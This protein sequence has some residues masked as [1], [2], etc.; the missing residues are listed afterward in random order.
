[1]IIKGKNEQRLQGWKQKRG[2]AMT[3]HRVRGRKTKSKE[4]REEEEK[5]RRKKK[6]GDKKIK[7]GIEGI[8]VKKKNESFSQRTFTLFIMS[9]WKIF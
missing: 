4:K 6:E 1:M 9:I 3:R 7:Y 5:G 8:N 2:E